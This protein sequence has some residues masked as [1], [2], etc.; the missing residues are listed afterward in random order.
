[1]VER[2]KE[3]GTS[4]FTCWNEHLF[5]YMVS[6]ME[7]FGFCI[8]MIEDVSQWKHFSGVIYVSK[9]LFYLKLETFLGEIRVRSEEG[10]KVKG[11]FQPHNKGNSGKSKNYVF[12][13]V[14]TII[15]FC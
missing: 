6:A 14:M 11:P 10:D 8:F 3:V 4:S 13:Y 1:M 7:M 15:F 5:G 2:T 12:E 9:P